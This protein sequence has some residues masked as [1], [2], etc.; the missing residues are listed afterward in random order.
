MALVTCS[1]CRSQVSDSAVSCP[2]CGNVFTRCPE[3]RSEVRPD[4]ATCKNCGYPLALAPTA[5]PSSVAPPS[6]QVLADNTLYFGQDDGIAAV[7]Y[8]G[9][10]RR[11]AAAIIDAIIYL[12]VLT[13]GDLGL[14]ALVDSNTG[15]Y[16]ALSFGFLIGLGIEYY[17]GLESSRWQATIGKR[18]LG[19][20]VTD[21][22][23]QRVS[24]GRALGRYLLKILSVSTLLIGFLMA[25]FTAKKQALDDM[26]AGTLVVVKPTSH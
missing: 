24:N 7:V 16:A 13:A 2:Q 10:W 11:F 9:F 22:H 18:T 12:V 4:D 21:T 14:G 26:I 5:Q 1:E 20:V 17:V 6:S 8:A 25:G 15:A 23:G 3:C 19:I